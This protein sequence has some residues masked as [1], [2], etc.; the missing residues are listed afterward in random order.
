MRSRN[1]LA[2]WMRNATFEGNVT[3]FGGTVKWCGSVL[4]SSPLRMAEYDGPK[5]VVAANGGCFL[6][7]IER[8]FC[9]PFELFAW[10]ALD[11][12]S[13]DQKQAMGTWLCGARPVHPL[14]LP[15]PIVI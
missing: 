7:W 1:H 8:R 10:L 12:G 13:Y 6:G 2:S 5:K 15:D 3:H 14:I 9:D 11:M 4:G